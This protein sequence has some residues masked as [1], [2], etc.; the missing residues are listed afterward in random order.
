MILMCLRM[1]P[2]Y[3]IDTSC[4]ERED[5]D[6][7]F[8]AQPFAPNSVAARLPTTYY[9]ETKMTKVLHPVGQFI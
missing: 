8:R 5:G 1:S 4:V 2:S 6:F 9:L 7:L 3:P